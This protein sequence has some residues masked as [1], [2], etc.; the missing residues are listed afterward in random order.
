M[1]K[2]ESLTPAQE[3]EMSAYVRRYVA[4]GHATGRIDRVA[5]RE[6]VD[7]V[8]RAGGLEPPGE[9]IFVESPLAGYKLVRSLGGS[10]E[11]ACWG[12]HDVE[13]IAFYAFFREV[14]GLSGLDAILPLSRATQLGWFWPFEYSCIVSE[15]PSRLMLD[16]TGR[17]HAMGEMAIQYPDGVGWYFYHGLNIPEKVALGNFHV[18][19]IAKEGNV[20]VRRA[21]IAIYGPGRYL[22]EIKAKPIHS[23]DYGT[24][25]RAPNPGG[26]DLAFVKVINSTREPDGTYKDYYLGVPPSM[27]RAKQA[28]A[29]TFYKEEGD[30]APE[31]ET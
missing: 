15:R 28:V 3:R 7:A 25:Y 26:E 8:Y 18:A 17:L 30:Y 6:I 14:C 13:N 27:E 5:A 21:M 23:D 1:G 9:V 24:L 31:I 4:V 22:S 2:I 10:T 16:E 12:Q 29:W 11:M 19:D 20:E